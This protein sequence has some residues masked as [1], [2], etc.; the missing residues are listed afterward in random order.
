MATTLHT[1]THTTSTPSSCYGSLGLWWGYATPLSMMVLALTTL[2]MSHRFGRQFEMAVRLVLV[3]C[4][5]YFNICALAVFANSQHI[6][7]ARVYKSRLCDAICSYHNRKQN[8]FGMGRYSKL[9]VAFGV[10]HRP[11]LSVYSWHKRLPWIWRFT[12]IVVLELLEIGVSVGSIT[13]T[14]THTEWIGGI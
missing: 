2:W 11:P 8:S 10:R 1:H 6:R 13:H 5:L 7:S 3:R 9:R 12:Q 14:H 4:V